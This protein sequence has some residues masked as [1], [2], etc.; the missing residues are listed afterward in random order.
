MLPAIAH[1]KAGRLAQAGPLM[2]QAVQGLLDNGA[3]LVVLACTEAPMALA[4]ASGGLQARCVDSTLALAEATV[5][6]WQQ[7]SGG[8]GLRNA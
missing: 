5:S 7:C 1:V 6:L 8:S 3:D 2:A 4:A